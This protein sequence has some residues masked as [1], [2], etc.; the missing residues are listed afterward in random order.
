MSTDKVTS[1]GKT[2]LFIGIEAVISALSGQ[3]GLKMMKNEKKNSQKYSTFS[4]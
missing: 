4:I 1:S 3:H 2:I